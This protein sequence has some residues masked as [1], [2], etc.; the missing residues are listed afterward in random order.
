[1]KLI[2][3]IPP[4]DMKKQLI[5]ILYHR[6]IQLQAGD[7]YINLRRRQLEKVA[8]LMRIFIRCIEEEVE[9]ISFGNINFAQHEQDLPR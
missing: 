7:F 6:N 4:N 8:G 9:K 5:N 3:E 1:M 2:M